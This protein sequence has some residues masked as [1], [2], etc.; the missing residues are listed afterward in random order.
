[1]IRVDPQPEPPDFDRDVRQ[2]GCIFLS[3]NPNPRGRKL[4]GLWRKALPDLW[5][6]YDG[7]CAYSSHWFPL[8]GG[9]SVDHFVPKSADPGLAY[10]WSNYRL[11][12]ALLNSRKGNR[13][14][15]VDPF[16][17]TGDWFVLVFPALLVK[18]A[19]NLPPA[20]FNDVQTTIDALELNHEVLISIRLGYV[21]DYC[22]NDVT[23]AYLQRR[24]PFLAH[25]LIRQNLT[26]RIRVMMARRSPPPGP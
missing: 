21:L 25:E 1:M 16:M 3:N 20:L 22:D 18:P 11:S 23:L 14:D 24:A 13:Q 15:I 17:I 2:P 12:T 10:E 9:G 6:I 7:V 4:P 19:A 5:R 26:E 8:L